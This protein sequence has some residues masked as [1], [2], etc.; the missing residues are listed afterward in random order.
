[1]ENH[2]IGYGHDKSRATSTSTNKAKRTRPRTSRDPPLSDGTADSRPVCRRPVQVTGGAGSPSPG[3]HRL[4]RVLR[5]TVRGVASWKRDADFKTGTGPARTRG[6]G[7]NQ[8]RQGREPTRYNRPALTG[9]ATERLRQGRDD[10]NS[11]PCG[12]FGTGDRR[13][14]G[15]S[16]G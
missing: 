14:S 8:H 5:I 3:L 15:S 1:M 16:G 10:R 9:K 4:W 12:S 6:G 2:M 13:A 7:T 11:R